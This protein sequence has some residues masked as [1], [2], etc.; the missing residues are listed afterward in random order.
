M[1]KFLQKRLK[2]EKGLTLVELLAVIVILGII[3]AIAVPSIGSIIENSRIKAAKADA[4]NAM[5]AAQLYFAENDTESTVSLK[6]LQ[7]EG[8]MKDLGTLND[9][10]TV[11]KGEK[12]SENTIDATANYSG[13]KTV[14]FTKATVKAINDSKNSTSVPI[15]ADDKE[16]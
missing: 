16:D 9:G 15:G 8:Y 1:K 10:G 4:L 3:A 12:G 6:T 7:T 11:N 2:N 13:S 14:T 5:S